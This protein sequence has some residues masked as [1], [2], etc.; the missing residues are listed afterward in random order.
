[1]STANILT[2]DVE[3]WYQLSG[4]QI[5]GT[6]RPRPD[7]L[8]RQV[9]RLLEL[10]DRHKTRATFFCLGCSLVN[11]AQLVRR[12]A[13]AG[14]EVGSHGWDHGLLHRIGL[15][16]FRT[17]LQ[18]SVGWLQDLL[19]HP[20]AGYRAP[21]FSIPPGQLERFYDICLEQGL[22]YDSSVFPIRGR[23]YGI[24][25]GPTRPVFVRQSGAGRLAELPLSTLAWR[26]RRWPVAGGGYWRLLPA[27][28]ICRTLASLNRQGQVVVTYLH[29]YE[30]DPHRLSATSAAGISVRA[31]R[32]GLQQNLRR[33]SMYAKLDLLLTK[34]RFM[35]AEDYLNAAGELETY[36][37]GTDVLR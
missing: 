2:F 34:F 10:L 32:H 15:D 30:F 21:A 1:M 31:I 22:R 23:R 19:G 35:A 17:D 11:H 29:P 4:R 16:A 27:W 12:I 18:R 14:H 5:A 6:E 24:P 36:R 8:V 37:P 25:D 26:G 9:D 28:A 20:V 3:D 33:R 13:L 7:A